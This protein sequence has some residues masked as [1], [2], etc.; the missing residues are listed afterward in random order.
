[1]SERWSYTKFS[2]FKQCPAKYFHVYIARDVEKKPY[3]PGV[4]GHVH[5]EKYLKL[6]T[7]SVPDEFQQA[8]PIL[9]NLLEFPR[10]EVEH[11]IKLDPDYSPV[12]AESWE[13]HLMSIFDVIAA[14]DDETA[15]VIDW[16]TGKVRDYTLQQQVAAAVL[17]SARPALQE[18]RYRNV[19]VHRGHSNG[20]SY[21][22]QDCDKL[23]RRIEEH[24]EQVRIAAEKKD[25]PASPSPLCGWCPCT[26]EQ[27]VFAKK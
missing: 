27:C 17:L 9:N 26:K 25:W 22:R 4:T 15:A 20:R 24:A 6:E 23:V 12:P 18:I 2:T 5:L 11:T 16:K 7:T 1:M 10:L 13:Y 14:V 19:F 3:D 21:Y 8:L